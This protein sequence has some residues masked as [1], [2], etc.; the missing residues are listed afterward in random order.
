MKK[1]NIDEIFEKYLIEEPSELKAVRTQ[2][3]NL[4]KQLEKLH[5]KQDKLLYLFDQQQDLANDQLDKIDP[6]WRRTVANHLRR[7]DFVK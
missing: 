4:N 3:R 5:K 7:I 2:I 6:T 1:L